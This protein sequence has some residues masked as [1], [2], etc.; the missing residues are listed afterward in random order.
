[1]L[2]SA[3]EVVGEL[4]SGTIVPVLPATESQARELA[5]VKDPDE[6]REV[7]REECREARIA[8]VSHSNR[9]P[10]IFQVAEMEH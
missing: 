8:W 7:W 4:K 2:M 9:L 3:S 5:K 1:M 6:R 10:G